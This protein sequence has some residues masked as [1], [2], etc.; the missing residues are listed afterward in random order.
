MKLVRF[1][2]N[3]LEMTILS[4]FFTLTKFYVTDHSPT[5]NLVNFLISVDESDSQLVLP[6]IKMV[7]QTEK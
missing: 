1:M 7:G 5:E 3:W 6:I 2:F 4:K